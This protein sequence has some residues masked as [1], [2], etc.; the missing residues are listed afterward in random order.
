MAWFLAFVLM[1]LP[2]GQAQVPEAPTSSVAPLRAELCNTPRDAAASLVD[3]LQSNNWEEEAAA[4]CLDVAEVHQDDRVRIA[5]QLKQVMDSR[6][7]AVPT[8]E[9]TTDPNYQDDAG[10]HRI[11]LFDELP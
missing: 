11:I 3:N 1:W 5:V 8:G 4:A 6:G 9:L 10:E 2:I 7:L